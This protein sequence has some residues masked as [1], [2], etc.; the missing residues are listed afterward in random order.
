MGFAGEFQK[1]CIFLTAGTP[2]DEELLP[3]AEKFGFEVHD[4]Y[5]CQEFGWLT[6]DGVPLRDDISLVPSP[7]GKE[8]KELVVGGLPMGDSFLISEAGHVCNQAGKII[9]Y[10]R[11]RTY[12]EYD[13]VITH[14]PCET[15]ETVQRAARSILRIKGRI[16]RVS[17]GACDFCCGDTV[18]ART[19]FT[20]GRRN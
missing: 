17:R 19:G 7:K 18:A 20:I 4:L 11:E 16:V 10:K 6:L 5:G 14:T 9:T 3:V 15:A 2:L 12:P 13:V 8:Y 1:Q